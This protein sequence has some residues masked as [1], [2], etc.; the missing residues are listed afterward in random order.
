MYGQSVSTADGCVLRGGERGVLVRD[1]RRVRHRGKH[2]SGERHNMLAES[3]SAAAGR[4]L[5]GE[6]NMHAD[7]RHG[8]LG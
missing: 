3:M 5:C 2:L 8:V 4:V 7:H 1:Q 6:R